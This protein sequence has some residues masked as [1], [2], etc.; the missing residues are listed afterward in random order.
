MALAAEIR[1]ASATSTSQ[2]VINGVVGPRGD[3]YRADAQMTADEAQQYHSEQIEAFR[4]AGADMVSAITMNYTEEA[5]GITRAAKANDIPVVI[6]FTVETDGKL[7]TGE[8]LKS[9][10][11]WVDE[12]TGAAPAYYMI[13]CAHPSHFETSI[14]GREG[15]LD[16][17]RGVRANVSTKSHAE[18]DEA[19]ELDA[20]DPVALGKEY[21]ELRTRLRHL[22]VFGGCC[23]TDHRHI[24]AI[25][26]ACLP[27]NRR[28]PAFC[29][30]LVPYCAAANPA[31]PTGSLTSAETAPRDQLHPVAERWRRW[32]GQ[33]LAA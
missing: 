1:D 31:Q 18:L 2:I 17:I 5:I 14:S 13:N 19:Q 24:V 12:A 10:I 7:A 9:A 22:S 30:V 8:T 4:D 21:R 6:A 29:G 27:R 28:L 3:G 15:W 20:G 32:R 16:R 25:C 23:G 33:G 11:N 26:D